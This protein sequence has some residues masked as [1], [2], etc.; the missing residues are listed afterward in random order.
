MAI[1]PFLAM[2][3]AEIRANPEFS[4]RIGWM[5]CHFSPYGTGLSNLPRQLPEGSLLILNDRTPWWNHDAA[6]IVEQLAERIENLGCHGLLLDFQRSGV[7]EVAHLA[8]FLT[9]QLNCPVG[10]AEA[11]AGN[12]ECPVFLPPVPL[13][14]TVAEYLLPWQEREIWLELALDAEE[15]HLTP[16]G[17]STIPL[18]PREPTET[19]HHDEILHCGYSIHL[20]ENS[21]GFSLSRSRD[22]LQPLLEEAEHYGV[23]TAVGLWQELYAL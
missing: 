15:I 9:E 10:V 3:A 18:L 8:G 2:T 13:H 4:E 20:E 11:Y 5:A 21:A 17:A 19:A 14:Q 1:A 7:A 6:L 12:L 23:T 22:D 16:E